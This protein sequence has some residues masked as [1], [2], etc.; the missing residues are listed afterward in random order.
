VSLTSL[1]DHLRDERVWCVAARVALHDGDSS[2][3]DTAKNG[4][5]IISVRTLRNDVPIWAMM[6]GGDVDGKGLWKIPAI[7]TEVMIG[8]D[9]GMFEGDAYIMG[10]MGKP[11]TD[12]AE[13]ETIIADD[14]VYIGQKI[15]AESIIKAETF[16]NALDIM[17]AAIA[18][19]VGTSGT[20]AGATAAGGA[21]TT[22]ITTFDTS[23]QAALASKGKVA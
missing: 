4:Q 3:F 6:N 8:F 18:T 13:G 20:P 19:A 17:L 5:L 22:A 11:P 2:H 21:I 15:G 16:F 7:G 14:T 9:D 23:I 10:F 12:L 1:R